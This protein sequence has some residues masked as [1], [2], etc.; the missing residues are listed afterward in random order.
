MEA[1]QELVCAAAREVE[2]P[3][4]IIPRTSSLLALETSLTSETLREARRDTYIVWGNAF[5]EKLAQSGYDQK[6]A[7]EL[8]ALIQLMSDG[9]LISSLTKKIR[10][11]FYM[12]QGRSQYYC[13]VAEQGGYHGGFR[14]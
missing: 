8:G 4:K 11:R 13:K 10:G 2:Q 3:E 6:E 12:W 7:R 5:T 14:I 1:I 9:A